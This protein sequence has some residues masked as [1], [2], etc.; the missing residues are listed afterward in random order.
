MIKQLIGHLPEIK[1]N[2]KY[3]MEEFE[4]EVKRLQHLKATVIDKFTPRFELT[5]HNTGAENTDEISSS[6]TEIIREYLLHILQYGTPEER[7]K[8]LGG[9]K[10]KFSLSDRKLSLI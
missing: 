10:S 7:L 4:N 5:Q 6:Q 3:L 1:L 2:T 9:V 8:I